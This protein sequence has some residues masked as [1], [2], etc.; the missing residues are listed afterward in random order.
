MELKTRLY[1]EAGAAE[2]WIVAE[3]GATE[4]FDAAGARAIS[5]C[6]FEP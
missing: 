2:V 6:P 4:V 5:R 3:D 1:L